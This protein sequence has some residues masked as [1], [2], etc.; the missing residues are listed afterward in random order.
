MSAPVSLDSKTTA[1]VLID[2]QNAVANQ[3]LEPRGGA[4][5]VTAAK[6]LAA[7]FRDAGAM[8]VLVNVTWAKDYSDWPAVPVDQAP[9]RPAGGMPEGADQLVDGLAQPGDIRVTKRNWSA[10]HGTELDLLLRRRG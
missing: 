4:E 9:T 7:R 5:V 8:V 1:L 6:A 2:L 10:F 3:A